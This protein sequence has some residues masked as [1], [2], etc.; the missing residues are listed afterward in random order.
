MKNVVDGATIKT[1]MDAAERGE[2]AVTEAIASLI[3]AALV[4]K[5]EKA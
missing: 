4:K 5:E 3:D 1:I 2:E